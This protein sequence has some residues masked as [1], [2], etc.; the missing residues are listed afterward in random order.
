MNYKIYFNARVRNAFVA[1]F[2]L[3]IVV[4]FFNKYTKNKIVLWGKVRQE[5]GEKIN[6]HFFQGLGGIKEVKFFRKENHFY[7][8]AEQIL[9][10]NS[11]IS[12]PSANNRYRRST[13][14]DL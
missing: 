6:K 11:E 1:A 4:Y 5:Q 7:K 13:P 8:L 12:T 3:L 2:F 10:S 9:K 14:L